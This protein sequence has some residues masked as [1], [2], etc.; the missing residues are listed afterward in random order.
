VYEEPGVGVET[1][2]A[3]WSKPREH[4]RLSVGGTLLYAEGQAQLVDMSLGGV[5]L[6]PEGERQLSI[7]DQLEFLI[8][9]ESA[10]WF[11][12]FSA[13]VVWSQPRRAGL[14]FS[15]RCDRQAI[16]AALSG[17]HHGG[18]SVSDA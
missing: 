4:P 6:V 17:L 7:G 5:G 18:K 9:S 16:E 1:G 13:L 8:S 10:Q 2:P 3:S 15:P 11:G 14:K 12:P